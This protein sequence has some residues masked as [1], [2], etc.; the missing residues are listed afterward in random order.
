[1]ADVGGDGNCFS[2]AIA[3]QLRY[4]ESHHEQL[5]QSAV[6]EVIGNPERY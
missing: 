4:N 5:R 1:M 6:K 2:R 3:H